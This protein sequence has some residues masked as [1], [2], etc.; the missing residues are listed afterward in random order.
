MGLSLYNCLCSWDLL[1]VDVSVSLYKVLRYPLALYV[2]HCISFCAYEISLLHMSLCHSIRFYAMR[3]PCSLCVSH[4]KF[5][6]SSSCICLYVTLWGVKL[7]RFP[8]C[9]C[10]SVSLCVLTC[11]TCLY[12]PPTLLLGNGKFV[13]LCPPKYFRF[14]CDPSHS[15]RECQIGSA[16]AILSNFK[17]LFPYNLRWFFLPLSILL[18]ETNFEF[19]SWVGCP[20]CFYFDGSSWSQVQDDAGWLFSL[21]VEI[22]A[23]N[24]DK[25]SSWEFYTRKSLTRWMFYN[26]NGGLVPVSKV[27]LHTA[28]LVSLRKY[29]AAEF[30]SF[31]ML[32]K[33]H[34]NTGCPK[35]V[36]TWNIV[37]LY[38]QWS[39]LNLLVSRM[40]IQ[41]DPLNM[42]DI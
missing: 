6:C 4:Y 2:S 12:V 27:Q 37:S 11:C 34:G 9:N 38:R 1:A 35:N 33:Q 8:S 29:Q 20:L 42:D 17:F 23:L 36:L 3:P 7:V 21:L 32:N 15:R 18:F 10:V 5:L 24:K 28:H 16:H 41:R 13:C 19:I 31:L 39:D 30:Y 14:I 22:M 40:V 25:V 26:V